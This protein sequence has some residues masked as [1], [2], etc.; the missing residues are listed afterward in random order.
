MEHIEI[1]NSLDSKLQIFSI[2]SVT[3]LNIIEVIAK[4]ST[5][6][7]GEKGAKSNINYFLEEFGISVNAD[8]V[9]RTS[10]VQRYYHPKEAVIQTPGI[11]SPDFCAPCTFVYPYG[12][13][14]FISI[15]R[16]NYN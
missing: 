11:I 10:F 1:K 8:N 3:I 12:I 9:I 14:G 6:E 13:S 15:S 4:F 16:K 7:Q 5:L 2:C